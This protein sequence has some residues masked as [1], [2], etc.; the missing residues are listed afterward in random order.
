M[1]NLSTSTLH[2]CLGYPDAAAAIDFLRGGLGFYRQGIERTPAT[3]RSS[4][5]AAW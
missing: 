2:A 4:E 5:P 1:T 3:Y